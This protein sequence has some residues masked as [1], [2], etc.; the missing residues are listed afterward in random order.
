MTSKPA[1]KVFCCDCEYRSQPFVWLDEC[2]A[3]LAREHPECNKITGRLDC[4]EVNEEGACEW[5]K[6]RQPRPEPKPRR[7]L[8][9]WLG[10]RVGRLGKSKGEG[11]VNH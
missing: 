5:F 11:G 6:E 3:P 10:R 1:A 7:T 2:C 4:Y 9:R 8:F